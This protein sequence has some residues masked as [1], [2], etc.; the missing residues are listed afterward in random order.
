MAESP[1]TSTSSSEASFAQA[2]S[3][4]LVLLGLV[5]YG[6]IVRPQFL[7]VE[8]LPLEMIF[9]PAA[10]I[11]VVML[12]RQGHGWLDIQNSI[13]NKFMAALPAFF[14][15]F[16]IGIIISSWVISGTIPM[17]VYYGIKIVNP[18]YLYM[19]CFL[20]PA[21][22]STLT[23]TSYGSA[24]TIGVVLIGVTQAVGGDLGIAA[25]AIIGGAYFG[26]KLSPLS[27]STNIA[28][29][30]ADVDLFEHIHSMLYTTVPSAIIAT[31]IYTIVG[32]VNPPQIANVN[33]D[34]VALF[35]QSLEDVFEFNV[36]L[37][38]PAVIVLVGSVM[39]KPSVPTLLGS[40]AVASILALIFQPFS[41]GQL[42][43]TLNKGF[44][45]DMIDSS[46]VLAPGVAELLNRGGL[47][48][49][50]D[51]IV[52]AFTVFVYIGAIGHIRAMPIVVERV[53]R[54][55]KTRRVT[56][57]VS[58]ALT[59]VTNAM[60]SNQYATSFIVGDA[61]KVKYDALGINRKVLS[62]SIEDYGTMVES[63]VP[64]TVTALF[65]VATLGVPFA[66]YFQ[67]QLLSL[68]NLI[69]APVLVLLGI[70][71]F[72]KQSK[73]HV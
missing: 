48:A 68:V 71:M 15:L 36:V 30:A 44:N 23:G 10:I 70:G 73:Q 43:V 56:I 6:L 29:I 22:F 12:V 31:T 50:I 5:V 67:W 55:A 52:I 19:L 3:P 9:I 37:L 54:F 51:A 18:T 28:A 11:A 72:N 40:A 46:M 21:V 13:V 7:G 66:D 45:T 2:L 49:L 17:L 27:D 64:W 61:F 62:R 33:L 42:A 53:F 59:A 38:L 14:I 63:I 39:R 35:L 4:I 24:G 41:L 16:S 1:D 69:V 34:S 60:T 20:V 47:Y 57:L 26:D 25:G 32:F 8:A 58:L 65:M